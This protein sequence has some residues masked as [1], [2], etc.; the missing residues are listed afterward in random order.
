[1]SL[2]SIVPNGG[3]M[4]MMKIVILRVY[5]LMYA[6]RSKDNK[7][8]F[9]SE[10]VERSRSTKNEVERLAN[11]EAIYS[12]VLKEYE[13]EEKATEKNRIK[14][15]KMDVKNIS[16][17]VDLN[18]LFLA[19]YEEYQFSKEQVEILTKYREKL[20]LDKCCEIDSRVKQRLDKNNSS[21]RNINSLLKVRI[22]DH[23]NPLETVLLSIWN[24]VEDVLNIL[25]EKSVIQLS[26]AT[27]NDIREGYLQITAGRKALFKSKKEN[28]LN[29]PETNFRR[30]SLLSEISTTFSPEFNEFDTVGIVVQIGNVDQKFQSVY[31]ADQNLNILS[32]KFPES[33]K[34]FAYDDLIK[35]KSILTISNLKWRQ[36]VC[37]ESRLMLCFAT[38]A[39][40][41]SLRRRGEHFKEHLEELERRIDEIDV[42]EFIRNCA[43]K[44]LEVKGKGSHP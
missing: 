9:H 5:P 11:V 15:Q 34:R 18:D 20:Y 7:F 40:V 16:D 2:N 22:I 25:T 10:K 21:D 32:I 3:L 6:K 28:L 12:Q 33:I 4:G 43:C 26:N 31:I 35:L 44:I 41:F 19:G 23:K 30:V 37:Q 29:F 8:V 42:D 36:S 38:E 24:P 1:M 39:S 14:K 27:S 17:P 13:N